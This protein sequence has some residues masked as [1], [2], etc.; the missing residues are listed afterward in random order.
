MPERTPE[1][2][3]RAAAER[4]AR[5]AAREGRPAPAPEPRPPSGPE[6][7][8][9]PADPPEWTAPERDEALS[10]DEE[11]VPSLTNG[12]GEW[13]APGDT[14][15]WAPEWDP[16]PE[17]V[18]VHSDTGSYA[19]V[20]PPRRTRSKTQVTAPPRPTIRRNGQGQPGPRRPTGAGGRWRRRF[21]VVIAA[22]LLAGALWFINSTFQPFHGAGS[23]GVRVVIPAGADAG[24][25]GDKL[26]RAGVIDSS[27][28]FN[29][30]ATLT[31]RRGD[32]QSGSYLLR[33]GMTNGEAI[34]ALMQGPKAKVV[35]TFTVTIP[36]GR[37]RREAAPLVRQSGV[38]GD[39][40]KAT[41][42]PQFRSRARKL[43][44]PKDTK[45][46]EGFLF[47]ATYSMTAGAT[48]N[49]LVDKQLDAFKDNFAKLDLRYAKRRNL[50]RYDVLIIASMI[51]REASQD[52]ERPLIAA[53]IYNRLKRGMPLGIDATIRYAENNWT[54]PL[55]VSELE[56]DGP[57]NT[58]LNRGLPPTPIGNP[59]LASLRAA[60]KPANKSYLFYVR[61]PGKSG[62]H[63]FSSTDAQFQRD[64]KR[65]QDSREK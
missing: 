6:Q 2:R 13:V 9:V 20:A 44:L 42:R 16:E 8:D 55:R 33:K 12:D 53:V 21:A 48:A 36:E 4:A 25:I 19:P 37:S 35:K 65:Y 23:G 45:T 64:V 1:E 14:A 61:K 22:A 57:Y 50:T 38:E 17:P 54:R 18:G 58:R 24:Q 49:N 31:M 32:L 63:A 11:H 40:L 27:F 26:E 56:R 43:G 51:E 34:D 10:H 59:G 3:A 62:E 5:R 29:V 41:A 15:E 7:S 46:L 52:R 47:P 28:F 30:N 39:Y 60:V